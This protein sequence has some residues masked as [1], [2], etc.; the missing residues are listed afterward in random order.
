MSRNT[1]SKTSLNEQKNKEPNSGIFL[2]TNGWVSETYHLE[3]LRIYSI[4]YNDDF[5]RIQHDQT[6]FVNISKSQLHTIVA[7]H[8][9]IPYIDAVKWIIDHT[10]PQDHSF[11]D[12]P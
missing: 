7:K 6:T 3:C 8:A 4:F 5:L 11:N 1:I 10:L 2:D 9:L 12:Q